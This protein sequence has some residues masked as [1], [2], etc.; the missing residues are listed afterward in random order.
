MVGTCLGGKRTQPAPRLPVIRSSR[1]PSA[2]AT[3]DALSGG[4]GKAVT[5]AEEAGTPPGKAGS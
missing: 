4:I 3:P 2:S 1:H 5:E